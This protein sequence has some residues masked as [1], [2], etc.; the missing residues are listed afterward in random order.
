[1]IKPR[2]GQNWTYCEHSHTIYHWKGIL[3]LVSVVGMFVDD[4]EAEACVDKTNLCI[5]NA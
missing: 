1:M 3:K 2:F 5:I 4:I